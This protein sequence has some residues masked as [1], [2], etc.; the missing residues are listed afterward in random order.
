MQYTTTGSMRAGD[1]SSVVVSPWHHRQYTMFREKAISGEVD[2]V[3][4]GLIS[5]AHGL[6]NKPLLAQAKIICKVAEGG[7]S[8]G[9]VVSLNGHYQS[10]FDNTYQGICISWGDTDVNARFGDATYPI[11]IAHK[12]DGSKWIAVS[13]NWKIIIEVYAE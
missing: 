3:S 5:F 6:S 8:I 13:N 9:D 11:T 2:I 1:V 7:Y 4:G 10:S 12:G